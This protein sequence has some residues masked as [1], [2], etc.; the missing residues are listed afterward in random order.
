MNNR[1][2]IMKILL[3]LLLVLTIVPCVGLAFAATQW[4]TGQR[5]S[6]NT[7]EIGDYVIDLDKRDELTDKVYFSTAL[8]PYNGTFEPD[9]YAAALSAA[10]ADNGRSIADAKVTLSRQK[11]AVVNYSVVLD[12]TN[13]GNNEQT[14]NAVHVTA[15][16]VTGEAGAGTA[17]THTSFGAETPL[18][19]SIGGGSEVYHLFVTAEGIAAKGA[20]KFDLVL[21]SMPDNPTYE[22]EHSVSSVVLYDT[23][24]TERTE[25]WGHASSGNDANIIPITQTITENESFVT[26]TKTKLNAHGFMTRKNFTAPTGAFTYSF[27]AKINSFGSDVAK[28]DVSST[29]SVAEFS[30]RGN[31]YTIRTVLVHDNDPAKCAVQDDYYNTTKPLPETAKS[32][33]VVTSAWH[34]YQVVVESDYSYS[35]YVDG[36]LAWSGAAKK[37]GGASLLKIGADNVNNVAGSGPVDVDLDYFKLETGARSSAVRLLSGKFTDNAG[38][39]L[40]AIDGTSGDINASIVLENTFGTQQTVTVRMD[41]IA[42]DGSVTKTVSQNAVAGNGTIKEVKLTMADADI[43]ADRSNLKLKV[44]LAAGTSPITGGIMLAPSTAA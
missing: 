16:K 27:R 29:R 36:T 38:D 21:T 6:E 31:G 43:G 14:R 33:A 10:E 18:E 26:L 15:Y 37:A 4:M 28:P 3:S 34:D 17:W 13:Y 39:K 23:F 24:D 2:N 32:F 41:L 11:D 9:S 19:G 44:T 22:P 12:D 7:L 20:F 42:A 8:Q 25:N 1:K 5:S 40:T 30:I 35:V